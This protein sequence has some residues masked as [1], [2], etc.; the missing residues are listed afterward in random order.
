MLEDLFIPLIVVGLAEFGD[1][2]QLSLFIL[3]S[4]TKKHLMLL[5]GTVLAFLIVDGVAILL[6]DWIINIVPINYI[7]IV[8]GIIF[9]IFGIL[10]IFSKEEEIEEKYYFKN[11][12]LLS[13]T[14]IFLTEWGDKTQIAAALFA[15]KY[16]GLFV[17]LGVMIALTLL[18]ILAIYL[19]KMISDKIDRKIISKVAGAAFIIIGATFFIF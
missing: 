12:F 1:K 4:K 5:L 8:S 10:F 2:T 11:P 17:L 9:I 6:G 18:S 16:N 14:M 7:K 15:T 19:G 13:F 3:S